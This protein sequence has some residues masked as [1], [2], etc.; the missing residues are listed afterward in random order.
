MT[1]QD[2]AK[3]TQLNSAEMTTPVSAEK[4]VKRFVSARWICKYLAGSLHS[5]VSFFLANNLAKQKKKTSKFTMTQ[6]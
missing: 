3:M 6:Q 1:T 2:T 5:H 4:S